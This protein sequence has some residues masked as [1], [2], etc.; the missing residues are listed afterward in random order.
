MTIAPADA[1]GNPEN[2]HQVAVDQGGEITVTVTAEDGLRSQV[3]RVR[4][5]DPDPG[6]EAGPE[7]ASGA[8]DEQ[9]QDATP[10]P[11]PRV[12]IGNTDGMGVS[13]RNDCDDGARLSAVGGWPDG[14]EVEVIGRGVGRCVGWLLVSADGVTS[15]V[16][17]QYVLGFDGGAAVESKIWWVIGDT[18]EMS[19]SHRGD[20]ADDARLSAV[21][22]WS[23]GTE[24]DVLAEGVGRCTGW[25]H[26]RADGVTSWVSEKYVAESADMAA[27]P[28]IW[29]VVGNTGGAGVSHRGDCADDAR[30]SAVGGWP[31]GT[32]VDVLA[33]GVGRCAGWLYVRAD[34]VTSWVREKYVVESTGMAALPEIWLVVGNT[35][36]AGVSHRGDCAD[37]AR[38]S[39]VGGWPDGTE[40]KLLA[41]GSGPCAGWLRVEADGVTSRTIHAAPAAAR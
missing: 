39:A 26:V 12:V 8:G 6:S 10:E 35:G 19:V 36:G 17:G 9:P 4:I 31:D 37:D 23:D 15:W 13:H 29:L 5:E 21:G 20:C 41:K 25:L 30:L 27:L 1:D 28:E 33:E 18:D 34:G 24:V 38:L 32:E 16:R 22:G 3:Y 40:V 14:T 11:A 2:G 7:E